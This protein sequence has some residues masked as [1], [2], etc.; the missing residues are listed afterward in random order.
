[1]G[2]PAQ[3][4]PTRPDVSRDL[5]RR[6]LLNLIRTRQPL[7]RADLSRISGLHRSTVSLITDQLIDQRWVLEGPMGRL[8][9]GRRPTYLGLSDERT[10]VGVDWE[11]C[12]AKIVVSDLTGRFTAQLIVAT[13]DDPDAAAA[14][15]IARIRGMIRTVE[16][17]TVEGIGICG[18]PSHDVRT[19]LAESTGLEVE[20]HNPAGACAIG[21]TWFGA[22]DDACDT[23]VVTVSDEI[24][25][26]IL[27]NGQLLRGRNGRAGDYGHAQLDPNGPACLCGG[28]GCWTALAS[29]RAA[30]RYYTGS[31]QPHGIHFA[32]VVNL[33]ER[34]DTAAVKAIETMAYWLG[35]GLRMIVAGVAPERILVVGDVT[36]A[37]NRV[38]PALMTGLLAHPLAQEQI[39]QIVPVQDGEAARLRGAVA[40][41]LQ[42][43]FATSPV[44]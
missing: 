26:G 17:R 38:G 28:R 24:D 40:L 2:A 14:D 1:M 4:H 22:A 13:A 9:I 8:P 16:G 34:G 19:S 44:A 5:N 6:L 33:A 35:S 18:R 11:R 25:A 36:R 29:I 42:K 7:S 23:V 41:V 32:D 30:V 3:I 39:P 12:G 15:L 21:A 20:C 10:I 31:G 27:S 37:W 43:R